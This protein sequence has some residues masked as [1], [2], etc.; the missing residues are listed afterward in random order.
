MPPC[1]APT[2]LRGLARVLGRCVLLACALCAASAWAGDSA[3]A[4]DPPVAVSAASAGPELVEASCGARLVDVHFTPSAAAAGPIPV[5]A[6]PGAA[7]NAT[8]AAAQF[9]VQRLSFFF[10]QPLY[11][12]SPFVSDGSAPDA[13]PAPLQ[14]VYAALSTQRAQLAA[15]LVPVTP[16]PSLLHTHTA[17]EL[18]CR[19][20]HSNS[21]SS[22]SN[23]SGSDR[24]GSG[25]EWTLPLGAAPGAPY[26]AAYE[27]LDGRLDD[28]LRAWLSAAAA[29]V[30]TATAAAA[31]SAGTDA[32]A[33][34]SAAAA[35]SVLA[36]VEQQAAALARGDPAPAA[37]ELRVLTV[38]P[39]HVDVP[40]GPAPVTVPRRSA[41]ARAGASASAIQ[42]RARFA[43]RPLP[44]LVLVLV[45]LLLLVLLLSQ[46]WR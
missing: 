36:A 31:P 28:S 38:A 44:L 16:P 21:N 45:L 43:P 8:A 35:A 7:A 20:H 42:C 9:V 25:C 23:E 15:A 19:P 11:L 24:D 39:V 13:T 34:L 33:T 29:A 12:S 6:V 40:H 18:C 14:R 46:Q 32:S 17:A 30:T 27:P 10:D 22:S 2:H 37:N 41:S 5:A 26:W 4:P 3:D 1:G